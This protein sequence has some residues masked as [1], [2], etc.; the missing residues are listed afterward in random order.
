MC[1][2]RCWA[3]SPDLRD[4]KFI[5]SLYDIPTMNNLK[6]L[7][8]S[9]YAFLV[10]LI[11]SKRE[12]MLRCCGWRKKAKRFQIDFFIFRFHQRKHGLSSLKHN[13]DTNNL[14]LI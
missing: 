5:C 8:Q 11:I 2:E 1:I 10:N 9:A 4:K 6:R 7:N 3:I 12:M 14:G 13:F